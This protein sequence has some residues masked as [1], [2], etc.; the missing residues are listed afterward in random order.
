MKAFFENIAM[1]CSILILVYQIYSAIKM[2]RYNQTFQMIADMEAMLNKEESSSLIQKI[3]I[4][5]DFSD[6]LS[7]GEAQEVYGECD[8]NKKQIYE[9]LNFYEKLS[10]SIFLKHTDGKVLKNMYGFRILNTYEK[11]K[12]FIVIIAD[13]YEDPR[14][15]PYQHFEELYT[16]WKKNYKNMRRFKRK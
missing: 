12:P 3:R 11:L 7:L 8:A 15:K 14:I 2:N 16:R 5:E 13:H 4:L 1:I 6:R 10:L 9:I